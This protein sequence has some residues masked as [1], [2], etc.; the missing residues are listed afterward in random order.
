MAAFDSVDLALVAPELTIVDWAYNPPLYPA[1][2]CDPG[3][4]PI[5]TTHRIDAFMMMALSAIDP[6]AAMRRVVVDAAGLAPGDYEIRVDTA[7]SGVFLRGEFE[8]LSG[9]GT[10]R[11]VPEPGLGVIG[12]ARRG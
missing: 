4:C 1:V 6:R 8:S 9:V 11:V 10:V 7:L 5:I 2:L 12:L 3:H